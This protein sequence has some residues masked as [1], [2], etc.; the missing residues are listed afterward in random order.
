MAQPASEK[1]LQHAITL[2]QSG[3][4]DGAIGEYREYLREQPK[5]LQAR[6]NLGA[7]LAH[8][9]RYDEAIEEYNQ[10]LLIQP[11]NPSVLLN[12]ALAY[13]KTARI[14]EAAQR[15]EFVNT[16]APG[17]LQVSL[18]LADCD[19]RLGENKKV[20]AVLTPY[21]KPDNKDQAVSY[22]L[23][24]ALI[25]DNQPDRGSVFIDRILK[26]G[27]SAEAHLL[28]GTTKMTAFDY[29]GALPDLKK[30]TEM[31]ATLPEAHAYYGQAL[32]STGD[33]AGAAVEFRAE[34]KL[35]PADFLANLEMGVLAKQDQN[36]AE[37]SQYF[38]TALRSRPGD[39]GVRYQIATVHLAT[40]KIDSARA[41]L[42]SLTKESPQFT[43]AHVSL[44]TVYYRLKRKEDGDRERAIVQKLTAEQ[45]AKQPGV[46]VK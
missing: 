11:K 37:A 36:Y 25:R 17:N 39:P 38:E 8:V 35:N 7:A 14:P 24:M 34:L 43:E 13:Y 9:G 1:I 15:L 18:L 2:H 23:G 42:E 27:D 45:Q 19:L 10:A 41:E 5:S 3:D 32:L 29:A 30:A 20:I 28:M 46:N 31:N 33:P 21:D 6:S 4:F 26:A 22:L 44:A 40:G 16:L 12:L